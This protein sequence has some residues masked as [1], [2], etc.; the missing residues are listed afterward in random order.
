MKLIFVI[1]SLSSGGAERVMSSLVNAL[2]EDYDVTLIVFFDDVFYTLDPKV[3]YVVC[4]NSHGSPLAV[5][6]RLF[7][8]RSLL[9]ALKPNLVISFLTEINVY[10][11]LSTFFSRI[12]NVASERISPDAQPKF[13]FKLLRRFLYPVAQKVI[14]LH[15]SFVLSQKNACIIPN[16]VSQP[17]L[18]KT[19]HKDQAEKLITIGRLCDQKDHR[20]LIL[21][22]RDVVTLFPHVT[23]DIYG[24]GEKAKA[25]LD[26]IHTLNLA[27]NVF[28]RGLCR[29]VYS[30]LVESDIFVFPSLYEGF[31][32]AL[33]EAMSVGLPVVAT[34][35]MGNIV[36]YPCIPIKNPKALAQRISE[37]IPDPLE[38]ENLGR[39]GQEALE[40]Y[41]PESILTLWKKVILDSRR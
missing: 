19:H 23:L 5:F 10:T 3:N 18:F 13:I 29:D 26:L 4:P 38:R 22:M 41:T 20:T 33:A 34:E 36:P 37:L 31:P 24:E 16:A 28:L 6:K 30:V 17:P 1:S 39:M 14:Y 21:A 25:L 2:C 7:S 40:S 8:L 11:L 32:N 35:I 27:Q 9:K 12:P 15:P